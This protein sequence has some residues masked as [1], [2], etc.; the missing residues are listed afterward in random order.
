M[1]R[2]SAQYDLMCD[3]FPDVAAS[4]VLFDALAVQ[5]QDRRLL[6]TFYFRAVPSRR[7]GSVACP[8]PRLVPLFP[9]GVFEFELVHRPASG[10]ELRASR[11][12]RGRAAMGAAERV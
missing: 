1:R 11:G 8:P 4:C 7:A 3:L 12:R 9:V 2:D 10:A 5:F 6:L